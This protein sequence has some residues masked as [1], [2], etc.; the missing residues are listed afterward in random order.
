MIFDLKN[1]IERLQ[2]QVKTL[3]FA[4]NAVHVNSEEIET[5][6]TVIVSLQQNMIA[7]DR[8]IENTKK[9]ISIS[10]ECIKSDLISSVQTNHSVPIKTI[11]IIPVYDYE[12]MKDTR[13]E[14]HAELY[15][16]YV[17]FKKLLK[18]KYH[19]KTYH[20]TFPILTPD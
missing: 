2:S 19:E 15:S 20:F 6:K 16:A 7:Y 14:L 18:M 12:S 3:C 13:K 8:I 10:F 5:L 9:Q 1:R 4:Q 17:F 11:E